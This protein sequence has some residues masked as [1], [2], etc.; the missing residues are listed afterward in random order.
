[1]SAAPVTV[2]DNLLASSE[3]AVLWA[4]LNQPGWSHGGYSSDQPAAD[5]YFYKHYAGYR[6]S[7]SEPL[8]GEIEDELAQSAP[9]LANM[10]RGLKAGP[11]AGHRL[12]RCY[13]NGMPGGAEGGAHVDSNIPTHMTAIYYPHPVWSPDFGGETLLFNDARDEVIAAIYPRPNRLAIFS[14]VIPH[15]ARPM[16]RRC[17]DLRITLMFKTVPAE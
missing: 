2:Y 9:M 17:T 3:H 5:R 12:A 16:S 10:W 8:T 14:G 15:V 7:G 13:A 11:L 1:M 4:F 6:K